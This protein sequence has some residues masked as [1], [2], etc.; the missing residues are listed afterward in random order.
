MTYSNGPM[1]YGNGPMT[2]SNG[3]MTYS[4]G[5]LLSHDIHLGRIPP[6]LSNVILQWT[7]DI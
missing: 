7:Y 2:Y 5:P 1:T 4:N 6:K 3:P